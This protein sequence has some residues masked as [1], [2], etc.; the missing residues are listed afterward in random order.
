MKP[1][2]SPGRRAAGAAVLLALVATGALAF[3]AARHHR[4]GAPLR[5]PFP[6]PRGAARSPEASGWLHA[7]ARPGPAIVVYVSRTCPHCHAE[8]ERWASL[9]GT[10]PGLLRAVDFT[11]VVAGAPTGTIG[12]LVPAVPG[13]RLLFDPDGRLGRALHLRYV[14]YV[15]YVDAAGIVRRTRSGEV[16]RDSIRR[17]L[18][19]FERGAV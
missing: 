3:A 2:V 11:V 6:F 16:P 13:S 5:A 14:P 15:L 19:T 4:E 17:E 18:L 1:A 8:L 7:G 12:T 9:A 10:E